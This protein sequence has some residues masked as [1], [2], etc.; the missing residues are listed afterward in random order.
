MRLKSRLPECQH[1]QASGPPGL[2]PF[3]N[4]AADRRPS[5]RA[6]GEPSTPGKRTRAMARPGNCCEPEIPAAQ[7]KHLQASG[8]PGLL[9]FAHMA[10]DKCSS[11]RQEVSR[12][13]QAA[14]RSDG[15]AGPDPS[16]KSRLPEYQH[17]QASGPPGLL[18][19]ALMAADKSASLRR[20]ASRARR[21]AGDGQAGACS[22]PEIPAD[23]IPASSGIRPARPLATRSHGSGQ[24]RQPAG[25]RQAGRAKRRDASGGLAGGPAVR[26]RSRLPEYQHL[27][28]SGPPGLLAIAHMAADRCASLRQE[29]SESAK[30]RDA[31]GGQAGAVLLT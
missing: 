12:A 6:R 2:L 28:A 17:L 1:L 18:P 14:D 30:R 20:E 13:R 24:V 21:D 16:L 23:R 5:P 25:K 10:A 9:P 8:P 31:S 27:Q 22:G 4:M 11:L 29:P 19:F 7:T 26:L 3:A 15:Q